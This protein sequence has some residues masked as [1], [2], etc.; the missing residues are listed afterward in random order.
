MNDARCTDGQKLESTTSHHHQPVLP[1]TNDCRWTNP[2]RPHF[3]LQCIG[4][5]T[6]ENNRR[7]SLYRQCC[8][9]YRI[10]SSDRVLSVL[11]CQ[12]KEAKQSVQQCKGITTVEVCIVATSCS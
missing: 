4:N 12:H 10:R 7:M 8:I 1:Y 3:T 11:C 5:A 9:R 2:I 6:H